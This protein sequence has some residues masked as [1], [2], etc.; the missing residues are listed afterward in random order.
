MGFGDSG[1][2]GK[3]TATKVEVETVTTPLQ[4]AE[5]FRVVSTIT[6]APL[7]FLQ[8]VVFDGRNVLTHESFTASGLM[9][10]FPNINTLGG[11]SG[12]LEGVDVGLIVSP[13]HGEEI[14][15]LDSFV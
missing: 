4:P 5:R 9:S 14:T 7:R 6:T 10:D 3:V 8:E 11:D 15:D 13:T 1:R 12:Y 2:I